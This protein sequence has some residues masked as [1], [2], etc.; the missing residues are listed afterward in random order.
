MEPSASPYTLKPSPLSSED[1]IFCIDTHNECL[2]EIKGKGVNGEIFTRLD[3]IKQSI[4]LFMNAKLSINPDHRFAFCALGDSTFWVL[5]L[6][7][8]FF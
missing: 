4:L 6:V 5:F 7:F 1:I 2:K 8:S 3:A